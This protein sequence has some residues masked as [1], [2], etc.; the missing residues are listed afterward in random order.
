[1][2]RYFSITRKILQGLL[3][4]FLPPA[5]SQGKKQHRNDG[6][7][8]PASKNMRCTSGK[9]SSPHV[10]GQDYPI[11]SQSICEYWKY[12]GG[13]QKGHPSSPLPVDESRVDK[14]ECKACQKKT[15]AAASLCHFP[16]ATRS[17]DEAPFQ[18]CGHSGEIEKFDSKQC[19][20]IL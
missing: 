16:S 4:C 5:P 8:E 13:C 17:R 7:K 1:M 6:K 20:E 19:G 2:C 12:D 15:N 14:P 18:Q 11:N 9:S 10:V 3:T